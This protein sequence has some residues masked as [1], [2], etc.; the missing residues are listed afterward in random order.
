MEVGSGNLQQRVSDVLTAPRAALPSAALGLLQ[1]LARAGETRALI[2]VWDAVGGAK[3]ADADT[4]QALNQLHKKKKNIPTGK[5]EL[6]TTDKRE[7]DPGRR[8]HKICKGATTSGRSDA[9]KEHL[10][11]A[12]GWL[13]RGRAARGGAPPYRGKLNSKAR[14]ELVKRLADELLGGTGLAGDK[15]AR[16]ETARGLATKLQM[17]K[18]GKELLFGK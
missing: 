9:A 5:L 1:E 3:V 16:L 10:D 15:R 7:L 17:T 11:A 8:L 13:E 14:F 6:P 18:R 2:R 4:W 12:Y